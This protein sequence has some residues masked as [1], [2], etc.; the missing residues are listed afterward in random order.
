ML[1]LDAAEDPP[2]IF[3]VLTA[4]EFL[5]KD[6]ELRRTM[7][8]LLVALRRR[9]P[10][11]WFCR[12]EAQGRGALH[13]NLLV[14]RVPEESWQEFARVLVD[15]WCSRVD[16]EAAGQYVEPISSGEAVTVYVANKI[17]HAAKSNQEPQGWRWKHRT[18]QT[19]GYLVR[20]AGVMREEARR[21]L[22]VDALVW[23]GWSPVAAALEVGLRTE[24]A[25]SLR[26][27]SPW[28]GAPVR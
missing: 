6:D 8:Q 28:S 1:Q 12:W 14:K 3:A 5:R 11:E 23:R 22:Q 24:Q 16:A 18:S 9:W 21:S 20:P 4:R 26:P 10:V 2:V 7:A 17:Q 13:V 27:C 19:R 25:W 15:R